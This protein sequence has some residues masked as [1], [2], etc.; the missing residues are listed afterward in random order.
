MPQLK[1]AQKTSSSYRRRDSP[2]QRPPV[3]MTPTRNDSDE[4]NGEE[5]KP[6]NLRPRKGVVKAVPFQKKEICARNFGNFGDLR[7]EGVGNGV[8]LQRVR[9]L[10]DGGQQAGGGLERK[11]KTMKL[12]ISLSREE[13]EEDVYALT[14][15]RP[16][17]RPRKWPKNVQKQL[18]NL[19][20][21]L[22]LV[23]V[24]ADSYRIHDASN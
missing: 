12:W 4:Q 13:I 16:A 10:M 19:Y 14:G 7:N 9:G 24:A 8:N 23:G 2:D 5:G 22:Y 1:W 21:G 17:R 15:S 6:W 11:E 3:S 18:D 20:P